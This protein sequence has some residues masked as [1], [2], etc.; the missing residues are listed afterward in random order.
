M[1]IHTTVDLSAREIKYL[2]SGLAELDRIHL[3]G[4]RDYNRED[5]HEKIQGKLENAYEELE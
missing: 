4:S 1:K 3:S 5:M 2:L